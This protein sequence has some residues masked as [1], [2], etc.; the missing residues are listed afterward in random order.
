MGSSAVSRRVDAEVEL[1]RTAL[2]LW[3]PASVLNSEVRPDTPLVGL[4]IDTR[5]W[6]SF[7]YALRSASD[8]GVVMNDSIVGTLSMVGDVLAYMRTQLNA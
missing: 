2:Q 8:E 5:T 6:V 7:A 1:F 4:G 3:S